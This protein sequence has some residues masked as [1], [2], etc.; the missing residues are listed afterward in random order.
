MTNTYVKSLDND[1]DLIVRARWHSAEG[2]EHTVDAQLDQCPQR[3]RRQTA[4]LR[5][6]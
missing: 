1:Q 5:S 3:G 2:A 6:Q 4:R